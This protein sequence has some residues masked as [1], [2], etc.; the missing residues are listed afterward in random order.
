MIKFY[1]LTLAAAFLAGCA[2]TAGNMRTPSSSA[3]M[4]KPKPLECALSE[5]A[6]TNIVLGQV[7]ISDDDGSG[8]LTKSFAMKGYGLYTLLATSYPATF[9]REFANIVQI[10]IKSPEQ[11]NTEAGDSMITVSGISMAEVWIN[12]EGKPAAVR[13][14]IK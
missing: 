3:D 1:V 13:C 10:R 14:Y 11:A 5:S 7:G 6:L 12:I 4:P 2:S 8:H 9:K